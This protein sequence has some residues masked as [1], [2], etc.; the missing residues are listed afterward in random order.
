VSRRPLI[1]GPLL[2][3]MAGFG[4]GVY[5]VLGTFKTDTTQPAANPTES[6][7]VFTLPGVLY[8]SQHGVIY[9]LQ[10]QKFTAITDNRGWMQPALLPDGTILAVRR[11]AEYSDLFHL[12]AN[13]HVIQ[14]LTNDKGKAIDE[15]HWVFYPKAS[16]VGSSVFYAFDQ[17][18]FGYRVDM[19]IWS[20]TL[21]S[22]AATPSAGNGSL[23]KQWTSPDQYTGGDIE[24]IPLANGSLIYVG[25]GVTP[26]EHI[27][28]TILLASAPLRQSKP[29]TN[30]E[31]DCS[32]P[33]LSPDGRT[34]AMV[35]T[36]G[37]Q[38][39]SLEVA[40]FDG[41][42][43]GPPRTVVSSDLVSAPVW[44]PDGSGLAYLA[45][46]ATGG[47]FQLWWLAGAASAAVAPAS[48]PSP[49]SRAATPS[50]VASASPSPAATAVGGLAAPQQ[51]TRNLDFDATSAPAWTAG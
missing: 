40:A 17:P 32:W 26:K 6:T 50:P 18:K 2:V 1:V 23:A 14:Q 16:P 45:P 37:S 28:A 24:P 43:L 34:L 10:G 13:G 25:Y 39:A 44:A 38:V 31:D 41:K 46:A 47:H 21:D 36:H 20:S 15:N 5:H 48:T 19:A 29:L 7:P 12:D 35:C 3:L 42:A 30:I 49:A 33:A 22:A 9:K 27:N 4:L 11:D 8:L 51:V